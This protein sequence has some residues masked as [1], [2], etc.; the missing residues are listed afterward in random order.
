MQNV[1]RITKQVSI[2]GWRW[3][4]GIARQPVFA[5]I[6]NVLGV[7]AGL[8]G[9]LYTDDIRSAFPFALGPY[10]GISIHAVIFWSAFSVFALTFLS[11]EWSIDKQREAA[12]EQL[13]ETIRTMPPR[14]FVV[15]FAKF[16]SQSHKAVQALDA[17]T[18]ATEAEVQAAIRVILYSIAQL[19]RRFDAAQ[20]YTYSANI[21]MYW[22]SLDKW[23][24]H[25]NT[26]SMPD[27]KFV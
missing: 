25:A 23:Q 16:Y 13:E 22:P 24:K 3:W 14:D 20:Q 8:L 15:E 2:Q 10:S 21:M 7:F 6:A 17:A 11:R 18:A 1:I 12:Q 26:Q 9:A 5:T 4:T 27:I 19:A